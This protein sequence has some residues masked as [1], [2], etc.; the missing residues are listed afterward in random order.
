MPA[1]R[2]KW[3]IAVAR[4]GVPAAAGSAHAA[5]ELIS[6]RRGPRAMCKLNSSLCTSLHGDIHVRPAPSIPP[7]G[8]PSADQIINSP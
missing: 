5:A 2:I 8:S 7:F 3:L 1:N 4:S 6:I